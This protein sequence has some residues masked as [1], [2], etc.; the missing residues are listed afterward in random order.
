M[1]L[2]STAELE[3][4]APWL[5]ACQ[6]HMRTTVALLGE[7][8]PLLQE[9]AA[10]HLGWSD[11]HAQDTRNRGKLMRP[12]V[13]LASAWA[14]G[15]EAV[16]PA[17]V[18]LGAAI[19]LLH[20]F[21]LVH[22][23]IQDRSQTRRFRPTVWATWGEAQAINAGDAL[24]AAAH[25]ALLDV[26][27]AGV[28]AE[29]VLALVRG[30]DATTIEIVSG[31]VLDLQFETNTAVEAEH[32]IEMITGKTARIVEFAAGAGAWVA[33]ADADV[34]SH[35]AAFGLALGVGFQIHDD[36]LGVFG[37]ER[38]TGKP[39]GDD[40]RRKKQSLPVLLLRE[41]GSAED[42][43][44]IETAYASPEISGSM[45]GQ[46]VDRMRHY[47]IDSELSQRVQHYHEAA[48]TELVATGLG[49][50]RTSL[51]GALLRRLENRVV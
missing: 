5:T 39:A 20:N 30:F 36:A 25:L 2:T 17:A 28:P 14:V 29:T 48:V 40:I 38:E 22:D 21:T 12:A 6:Q 44:L 27:Y 34:A 23:D 35:L 10:Y 46:I 19:E 45:V 3:T 18:P 49:A 4:L 1:P 24:Y 32:Y 51:L 26:E 43:E 13:A 8:A 7:R 50:Q 37:D 47:E 41:R 16:L 15:G 11:E 31:Q 33:G 9:M 42:R